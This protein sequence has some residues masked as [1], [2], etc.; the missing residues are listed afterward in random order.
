M[1]HVRPT[2][3]LT[4]MTK[5]LAKGRGMLQR[6]PL[7]GALAAVV[8][9]AA[10]EIP[11]IPNS[12]PALDLRWIV[13]AQSGRIAVSNLLPP[14]VSILPDSSAFTISITPTSVTRT[15]G[16]DCGSCNAANGLTVAKP[17]FI[18]SSSQTT[19]IPTDVA[20]ATIASG[21]LIVA[22][23]NNYTFDPLRPTASG[24]PRS[25]M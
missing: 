3:H 16:Q 1:H 12:A 18:G 9:S 22:V 14:G 15:L 11:N 19:T 23:R 5:V 25:E 13:P 10:C 6:A 20:S 7:F 17:A 21:T 2:Y 24:T 8:A 4:H